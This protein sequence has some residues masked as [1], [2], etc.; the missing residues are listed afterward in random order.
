MIGRGKRNF[1]DAVFLIAVNCAGVCH[2][3]T[4]QVLRC[5]IQNILFVC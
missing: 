5:G 4:V 3:S 2:E 1:F